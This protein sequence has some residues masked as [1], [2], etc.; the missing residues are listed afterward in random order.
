MQVEVIKEQMEQTKEAEPPFHHGL[1]VPPKAMVLSGH[2]LA[3]NHHS[4]SCEPSSSLPEDFIVQGS[5]GRL[6]GSTTS[7]GRGDIKVFLS[8]KGKGRVKTAAVA[9]R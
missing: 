9:A 6:D 5:T 3:N 4:K 7:G 8:V 2:D 1:Q